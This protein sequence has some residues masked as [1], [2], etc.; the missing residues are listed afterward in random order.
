[1][2]FLVVGL[3]CMR[4]RAVYLWLTGW[5]CVGAGHQRWLGLTDGLP[6]LALVAVRWLIAQLLCMTILCV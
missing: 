1:M 3:A 4:A 6:C 2:T 5:E